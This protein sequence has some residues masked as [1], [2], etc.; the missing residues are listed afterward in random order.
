M[1]YT[2]SVCGRSFDGLPLCYGSEAPW[3]LLGV[4]KDEFETRVDLTPDQCV[5]DESNF[6]V[7]G[8]IEI[9]ILNHE[10]SFCWS[11]WCSLSEKSFL[12]MSERWIEPERISDP[13]YFGW[14]MTPIPYYELDTIHL[15]CSVQ[16]RD[17]GV[18]PLVTLEHTSHPLAVD[19]HSGITLDRVWEIAHKITGGHET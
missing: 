1:G 19:L 2:C 18:V 5:V 6:F 3:Y 14:L 4:A 9:P 15:K 16:S 17:V 7:R 8:H 13:P 10:E 12:H 11:V